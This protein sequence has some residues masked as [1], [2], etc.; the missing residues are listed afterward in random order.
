MGMYGWHDNDLHAYNVVIDNDLTVKGTLSFGDEAVDNL[1]IQGRVSSMTAAGSAI[2]ITSAY[3]DGEGIE[4]RY[5]VTDWTGVGNSFKGM[6][7]RSEAITNT[8]AGKSIYGAEIYGVCNNVTMDSGSLWG[9]MNY[10]YVKGVDPV[11]VNNMYA[12][13][14]EL[15]WDASR[16]GD[17]TITTAAACFRAKITGGQVADYTKI[18]GYELTIGE[19][20]GDSQKFGYGLFMQDDSGMGGT[21]TL[22]KGVYLNIGCDTGIDIAEATTGINIDDCV[23]G[24]TIGTFGSPVTCQNTDYVAS[25][26]AYSITKSMISGVV[27]ETIDTGYAIRQLWSRLKVTTDQDSGKN[28]HFYGACLQT[29]I[30]TGAAAVAIDDRTYAGTWNYREQSSSSNNLTIGGGYFYGSRNML[31][32]I[33]SAVVNGGTFAAAEMTNHVDCDMSSATKFDA[34]YIDKISGATDWTIGIDINDCTTGISIGDCVKGIDVGTFGSPVTV[35]NSDWDTGD[36][37][38]TITKVMVSGV[39]D[40]DMS[41]SQ[42]VRQLWSRFK[43]TASQTAGSGKDYYGGEMQVRPHTGSAAIEL[44]GGTYAGVWNYW[45]NSDSAHA[46]TVSGGYH[47]GSINMVELCSTGVIS[48]GTFAAANM[49]NHVDTDPA[50]A[51]LFDAILIN[52]VSGAYD[53]KIGVD[54]NDCTTGIDIAA[55]TTGILMANP[56][57]VGLL[58]S[59]GPMGFDL[60]STIP[61]G[62]ASNANEINLTDN[63]TGSSGYA[64]ALWINAVVAGDKTTSGEHNSLGIDQ[65]VTG[66]TPYLYGLTYYSAD[67][68]DPTIGFA[69]PISVYQDDLGTNLGAYVC[70]DLGVALSNAPTDRYHYMRF[71][72]H[73]T[74]IPIS[75]FRFE[76]GHCASYLFDTTGGTGTPDFITANAGQTPAADGVLI[77]INYH[78]T[79]YY[80]KAASAWS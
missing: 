17:C 11:T 24:V 5:Q 58:I 15:S 22:S 20:D 66:N 30:H 46:L 76:G 26:S 9:A 80:I 43:I 67:V 10:A 25:G 60:T 48:G 62:A 4:M 3:T 35:Q 16:T 73:S 75:V 52:K 21:S 61:A 79:P 1:I 47:Y 7:L 54:V 28:A 31:E 56:S 27:S 14:G 50:S 23:M 33:S 32:L 71:R 57:T 13:Q 51:T 65:S 44:A 45:E 34:I 38:Y 49:T 53:W 63:S 74:A 69:A 70:I 41:D 6:Y 55:C 18:H 64:R 19:M 12:V 2:Q 37:A 59:A 72:D 78:G 40:E 68:G 77:A 39:L 8:A 29:R 36:G 42:C